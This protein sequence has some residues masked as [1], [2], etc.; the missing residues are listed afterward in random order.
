MGN[1]GQKK[2]E[3]YA[4]C[5]KALYKGYKEHDFKGA[6]Q[7]YDQAIDLDPS[8]PIIMEGRA[9]FRFAAGDWKG[10]L[11]DLNKAI[12]LGSILFP[13]LE[14][15]ALFWHI[16][17]YHKRALEDFDK[18]LAISP[19][20]AKCICER[21][22]VKQK[23]GDFLGAYI[24][25]TRSIETYR[26]NPEAYF[27]RAVLANKLKLPQICISDLCRAIELDPD[28]ISAYYQRGLV[29]FDLGEYE[30]A[31]HDLSKAISI[32]PLFRS[33]LWLRAKS[34]FKQD[35]MVEAEKDLDSV[36]KICSSHK[37][38]RLL[39]RKILRIK[40]TKP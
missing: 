2:S 23:T 19:N 29:Y 28:F 5:D 16:N 1:T 17:K 11:A 32:Y 39:K 40:K 26:N 3:A 13:G 7:F 33:A 21:G 15:R 18:A 30:K 14:C 22:L 6:V 38:A 34:Y 8:D 36:I 4:L 9:R 31:I 24:D 10:C 20:D 27:Y 37:E 35:L 25:F 12:E